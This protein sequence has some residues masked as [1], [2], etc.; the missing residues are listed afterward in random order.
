MPKQR[1]SE[2]LIESTLA[3]VDRGEV[4]AREWKKARHF[5][6]K[7]WLYVVTEAG[8]DEPRLHR[9][10]SPA[11]HFREGEDIFATGFIVREEIW[12]RKLELHEGE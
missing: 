10:Q 12:R 5:G 8:T 4:T 2:P 7:F 3:I 6:D 1:L 11:T 9:I